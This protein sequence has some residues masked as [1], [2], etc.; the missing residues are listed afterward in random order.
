MPRLTGLVGLLDV[1]DTSLNAMLVLKDDRLSP[2]PS[3]SLSPPLSLSLALSFSL[4]LALSLSCP[5]SL[6]GSLSP[7]FAFHFFIRKTTDEHGA[8]IL[9][10]EQAAVTLLEG[11]HDFTTGFVHRDF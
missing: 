8:H 3:L 10:G 7:P 4:S 6:A 2:A 11:T 9:L 5:P 1:R